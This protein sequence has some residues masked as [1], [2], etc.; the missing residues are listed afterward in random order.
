M[1]RFFREL[2]WL[3]TPES[4]EHH[5]AF[6]CTNGCVIALYAA[7]HYEPHFGRLA[8]GF[9]GIVLS[10]NVESFARKS[11]AYDTLGRIDG[12]ELLEEP[13]QAT[14]GGGFAWRDPEGNH[15]D[16]AWA[17]DATFDDRGGVFFP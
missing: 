17:K 10:I 12:A 6:Q 11:G 9:R 15:W 4:D 14:W 7:R 5:R 3:E 2:G 1:T 16:V 13:V 8:A